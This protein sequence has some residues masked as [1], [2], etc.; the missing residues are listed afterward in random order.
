MKLYIIAV[1][2]KMPDWVEIGYKEYVKRMPREANI[3]LIELKPGQRTGSSVEKAMETER[4]RILAALPAGCHKII[5]DERGANWTTM[6]LAEKLQGWQRNGGD[7]AFVIGGADGLHADIK[8]QANELLQLSALTLPHGMVRVLLVEQ[9]YR[10]VA[11][12]Q[13]HPYHRE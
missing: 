2:H 12:N 10:A 13:G 9:L 7:V 5:L 8:Q 3:E 4:D 11:I 1:G 6:K